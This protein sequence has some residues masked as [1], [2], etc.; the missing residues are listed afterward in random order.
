MGQIRREIN[1]SFPLTD[2]NCDLVV[3][4]NDVISVI[5]K[6]NSRKSDGNGVL[7]TDHFKNA[8]DDLFVYVSFLF[9]WMV[10][11]GTVPDDLLISNVIPIPKGKNNTLTDSNSFYRGIALIYIDK[12]LDLISRN[13]HSDKLC[14]S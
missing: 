12:I 9:S 7:S 6:L 1:N 13:R 4:M 5:S 10:V 3:T 8:S 2:S 14:K 11:H